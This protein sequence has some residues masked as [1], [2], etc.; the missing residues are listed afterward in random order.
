MLSKTVNPIYKLR[1]GPDGRTELPSLGDLFN[2]L[3]MATNHLPNGMILQVHLSVSS[4]PLVD[5]MLTAFCPSTM[6]MFVPDTPSRS[7][8]SGMDLCEWQLMTYEIPKVSN[9]VNAG[10]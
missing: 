2:S 5:R 1:N 3:A 10:R 9:A 6:P 8:R 7:F 4:V